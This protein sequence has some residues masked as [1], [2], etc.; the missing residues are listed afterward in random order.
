METTTHGRR[1]GIDVARVLALVVVVAGHLVLAVVDRAG[2]GATDGVRTANLL[3]LRPGWAWAAALA[4]MPVFFA[5]GGWANATATLEGAAPRLRSLVGTGAAVVAAWSV[6]VIAAATATGRAGAF[7]TGARLATQPLWFVAA[8]VPLA[9]GG[10]RIARVAVRHPLLAVGG[11][12]AVLAVLDAARF[13][14]GLADWIGWPGFWLAWGTPWL[15]GAWW[16]NRWEQGSD[17]VSG[18]R[19]EV[20][21]GGVLAAGAIVASVA[22]V[23]GAGYAPA[24]IDVVAGARSN[25]TP[26]TLYTAA[27]GLAQAGVLMVGAAA[28]DRLGRRWRRLWSRAGEAAVGLYAWHLSA[29]V[30]AVGALATGLGLGVSGPERLTA[31][32]WASRPLWWAAVLAVTA[33]LVAL[34][35]TARTLLTSSGPGPVSGGGRPAA[36]AAV[37]VAAAGCVGLWGPRSAGL[38]AVCAGLFLAS[39]WL[40]S[41]APSSSARPVPGTE[42][43]IDRQARFQTVPSALSST[44]IPR[45]ASSSRSSSA[46]AQSR[47]A[48]AAARSSRSAWT[49]ASSSGA[50]GVSAGR[51]AARPRPSRRS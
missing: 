38:A 47:A 50:S 29:L 36:G 44:V 17:P 41:P 31:A 19:A 30:L 24:L 51:P 23:A 22:L 21:G 48:R 8:Y 32:W 25:T 34:T 26:P 46:R 37:A 3:G 33:A 27:A 49:A 5:A 12:L 42:R 13:G 7:G 1:P 43:G 4:P 18:R 39:W 16:R 28:L 45:A 15:V 20:V 40:L 6:V 10:A 11:C 2:G 14:F 9:A 35:G